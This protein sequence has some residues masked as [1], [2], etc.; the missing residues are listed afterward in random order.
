[1]VV[2]QEEGWEEGRA[3]MAEARAAVREGIATDRQ[4]RMEECREQVRAEGRATMAAAREAVRT[5]CATDRQSSMVD[6]LDNSNKQA[7]GA[8][9]AENAARVATGREGLEAHVLQATCSPN[10]KWNVSAAHTAH[11]QQGGGMSQSSFYLAAGRLR[12]RQ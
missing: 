12:G 7:G 11:K 6:R 9:S 4:R 1:M 3:T 10:G 5:G 8:A 2:R